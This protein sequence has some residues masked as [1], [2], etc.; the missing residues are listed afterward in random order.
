MLIVHGCQYKSTVFLLF[1]WSQSF[2]QLSIHVVLLRQCTLIITRINVKK[3]LTSLKLSVRTTWRY[4][5]TKTAKNLLGN[6][7]WGYA[8]GVKFGDDRW[9]VWAGVSWGGGLSFVLSHW[10]QRSYNTVTLLCEHVMRQTVVSV[11]DTALVI[12]LQFPDVNSSCNI[13]GS[14][15]SWKAVDFFHENSRTWKVL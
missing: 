15:A 12:S 9:G 6:P 4:H 2:S 1:I 14:H 13:Q 5:F 3:N 8:L 7:R 10:F 11:S